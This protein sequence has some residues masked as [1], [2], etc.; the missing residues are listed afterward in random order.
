VVSFRK[1]NL[2]DIPELREIA[3]TAFKYHRYWVDAKLQE[4]R[5]ESYY[6]KDL[7]DLVSAAFQRPEENEFIVALESDQ[8]VGYIALK[9][10]S[11]QSS[12][13]GFGWGTIASFALREDRRQKGLGPKIVE[14]AIKWFRSKGV[15]KVDVWTDVG[16]VGAI[17][18]YEKCGFR[19][20]YNGI[21]RNTI[22]KGEGSL[23]RLQ[24]RE[25]HS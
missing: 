6:A 20:I 25:Y 1:V 23:P 3:S 17:Q 8:I 13:F 15:S 10:N 14:E 22:C 11:T 5:I 12:V 4:D 7:E 24:T 2:D 16:N 9:T 19:T 21:E 18:C